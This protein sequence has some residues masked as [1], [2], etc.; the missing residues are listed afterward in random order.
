MVRSKVADTVRVYRM[1]LWL[2]VM[3]SVRPFIV[4]FTSTYSRRLSAGNIQCHTPEEK[5]SSEHL[6]PCLHP[7]HMQRVERNCD[8]SLS[9]GACSYMEDMWSSKRYLLFACR[10]RVVVLCSVER[11]CAVTVRH[12]K[13]PLSRA[14]RRHRRKFSGEHVRTKRVDSE[15]GRDMTNVP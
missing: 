14:T 9:R 1:G 5:Q 8:V 4:L 11:Y 10:L 6:R 7:F 3:G 15:R 12:Q 13:E 2:L